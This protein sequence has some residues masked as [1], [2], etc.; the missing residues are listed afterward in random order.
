MSLSPKK[1]KMKKD[2][3]LISEIIRPICMHKDKRLYR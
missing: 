1:E 3:S 2:N